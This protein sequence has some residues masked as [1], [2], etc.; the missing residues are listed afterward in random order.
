MNAMNLRSRGFPPARSL[1]HG[2]V[3]SVENPSNCGK[4]RVENMDTGDRR[5]SKKSKWF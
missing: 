3:R 5:C 1:G 4:K 2:K